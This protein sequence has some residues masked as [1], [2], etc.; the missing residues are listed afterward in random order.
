MISMW[1]IITCAI[2]ISNKKFINKGEYQNKFHLKKYD[3]KFHKSR[4]CK[5]ELQET[6]PKAI[7]Q[8]YT[9]LGIAILDQSQMAQPNWTV[10]FY[11]SK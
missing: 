8:S 1:S 2:F 9:A 6:F 7:F 11:V 3:M 5:K 4:K 10:N